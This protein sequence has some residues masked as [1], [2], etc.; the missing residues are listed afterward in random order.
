MRE[1]L[2]IEMLK[3]DK[4]LYDRHSL[5]PAQS[6]ST[7]GEIVSTPEI[8]PHIENV[9]NS[10]TVAKPEEV[11][12]QPTDEKPEIEPHRP[13]KHSDGVQLSLLDLWGMTEEVSKEE[14]S[15]KKKAAKRK[16]P[17]SVLRPNRKCRLHR[18]LRIYLRIPL[19]FSG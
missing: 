10:E 2:S 14:T 3:F 18:R 11:T 17:Q 8:Q 13:M 19:C 7:E 16:V 1:H 5:H 12:P 15:K 4:K 6:K 9:T